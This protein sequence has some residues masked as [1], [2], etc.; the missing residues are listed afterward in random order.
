[1][2]NRIQLIGRLT[3]DP[4]LRYISSGQPIAQFTLAVDRDFRNADGAREADFVQCVTWRTLAE[5]VG[6]YC[7]KGRLVAVEG[8][9]QT[10]SYEAQDGTRRKSTEVVG[11]RVWF[12]DSPRGEDAHVEAVDEESAAPDALADAEDPTPSH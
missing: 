3:R 12:L 10:R 11:D 8:R 6:Q 7:T 5:Q 1:M 4:D 2:L 9:L